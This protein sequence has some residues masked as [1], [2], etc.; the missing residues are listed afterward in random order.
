L[1]AGIVLAGC[2]SELT[3]LPELMKVKCNVKVRPSVIQKGLVQDSGEM[4]GDPM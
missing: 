1:G 3:Y 4:L 2:A